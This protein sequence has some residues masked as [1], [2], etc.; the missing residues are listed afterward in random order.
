MGKSACHESLATRVQN[1]KTTKGE[2][3][4]LHKPHEHRVYTHTPCGEWDRRGEGRGG[5]E[6]QEEH[7]QEHGKLTKAW[8]PS[9]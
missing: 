2:R 6:E 9:Q 5:G 7:E 3:R 4:K 1:L 8:L